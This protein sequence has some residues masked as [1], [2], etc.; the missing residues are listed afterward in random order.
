MDCN[1][2]WMFFHFIESAGKTILVSEIV[3]FSCDPFIIFILLGYT[4]VFF[5][6]F[7]IVKYLHC[8]SKLKNQIIDFYRLF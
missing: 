6:L 4:K 2:G 8:S 3:F 7:R 5:S 1:N